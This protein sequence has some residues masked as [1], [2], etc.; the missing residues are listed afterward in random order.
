M[1]RL[2]TSRSALLSSRR[3]RHQQKG[4]RRQVSHSSR[5]IST[6]ARPRHRMRK[7]EGATRRGAAA[8]A[9]SPG[10][11][12]QRSLRSLRRRCRRSQPWLGR[13]ARCAAI[14]R[15][16]GGA[17]TTAFAGSRTPPRAAAAPS[18]EQPPDLPRSGR[19]RRSP[20]PGGGALKVW[21]RCGPPLSCS[22]S[23]SNSSSSSSCGYC[24]R[25][26]TRGLAASSSPPQAVTLRAW[27]CCRP[28]PGLV[29]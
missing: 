4:R 5:S 23:S 16:R 18:R 14:G 13:A 11:G 8:V 19:P 6:A 20:R 26:N 21:W 29:P 2:N 27:R 25:R 3:R 28:T 15:P 24:S 7:P 22:S 9:V 10:W 17:S 12:V 1:E